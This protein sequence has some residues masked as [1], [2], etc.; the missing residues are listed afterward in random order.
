MILE[1]SAISL[2]KKLKC[3]TSLK[4]VISSVWGS[5]NPKQVL[6]FCKILLFI[7][8]SIFMFPCSKSGLFQRRFLEPVSKILK[9]IAFQTNQMW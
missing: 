2:F 3:R 9:S 6:H 1:K 5:G 4:E 7:F 8:D